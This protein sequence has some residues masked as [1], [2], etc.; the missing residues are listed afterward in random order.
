MQT[1]GAENRTKGQSAMC[2]GI[3]WTPHCSIT[4]YMMLWSRGQ[5][6]SSFS[7]AFFSLVHS[8]SLQCLSHFVFPCV[9]NCFAALSLVQKSLL[10]DRGSIRSWSFVLLFCWNLSAL[11]NNHCSL[12]LP[13]PFIYKR[14]IHHEDCDL[15]TYAPSTLLP[16]LL[17]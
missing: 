16:P 14:N 11:Y 2:Q 9:F 13:L 8:H 3:F 5:A 17:L 12:A 7:H 10:K 4:S 1:K 6:M 15:L